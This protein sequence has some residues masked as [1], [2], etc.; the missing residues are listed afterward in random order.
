MCVK[1]ESLVT[2]IC[3]QKLARALERKFGSGWENWLES[4]E[5]GD[6]TTSRLLNNCHCFIQK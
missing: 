3:C 1:K 2:N 6:S 5:R 4:L